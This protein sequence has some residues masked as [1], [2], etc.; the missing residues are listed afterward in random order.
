MLYGESILKRAIYPGSFDPITKGHLSIIQQALEIFDY[1]HVI[2]GINPDK[3]GFI[4]HNAR[5]P[6][7]EDSINEYF[8]MD[9]IGHKASVSLSQ[10]LIAREAQ[11]LGASHIVRGLRASSDFEYEFM[12]NGANSHICPEIETVFFM[13][14]QEFMFVSSSTV[15]EIVTRDKDADLSW[16]VTPTIEEAIKS[17]R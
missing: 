12:M 16:L 10:R 8:E 14:P 3:R 2:V 5:V 7:S 15:R 11:H 6:L 4:D 9:I 13:P 17:I 1:L